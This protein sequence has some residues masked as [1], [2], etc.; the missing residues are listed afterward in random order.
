MVGKFVAMGYSY[1]AVASDMGM[2]VSRA[3]EFLAALR[4]QNA[5]PA[6]PT[7]PY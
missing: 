4:G 1:V 3:T 5:A 7:G 6:K 2:M